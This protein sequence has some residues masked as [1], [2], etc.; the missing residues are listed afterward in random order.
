[1]QVVRI[2][3]HSLVL[4]G[5]HCQSPKGGCSAGAVWSHVCETYEYVAANYITTMLQTLAMRWSKGQA[6]GGGG[7]SSSPIATSA[8]VMAAQIIR[9]TSAWKD[10]RELRL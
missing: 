9:P 6:C 8:S 5:M 10:S 4:I 7:W 1:M 2:A 3:R